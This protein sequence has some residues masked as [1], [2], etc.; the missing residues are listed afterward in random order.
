M[1]NNIKSPPTVKSVSRAMDVLESIRNGTN[2][3]TDISRR[4]NLGKT[5]TYRLLK[6]LQASGFVTQDPVTQHYYLGHMIFRLASDI[7]TLHQ[8][9]ILCAY[10]EME[11]LRELTGETVSLQ[12]KVGGQRVLLEELPSKQHIK[13]TLG[14]GFATPLHIGSGGKA[15]LSQLPENEIQMILNCT[16]LVGMTTNKI[17]DKDELLNEIRKIKE[18]GYSITFGESLVGNA[19]LAVPIKNYEY[20]AALSIFGPDYRFNR[21]IMMKFLK[22]LKNSADRISKKLIKQ[23]DM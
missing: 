4:A 6:T 1:R 18:E 13:L 23:I 16:R 10:D 8:R 5:T 14:H 19:G 21:D 22:E 3:L 2:T 15:L 9:L 17:I 11:H 20:P 12:I 7:T